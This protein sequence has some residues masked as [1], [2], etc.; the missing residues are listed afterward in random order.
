MSRVKEVAYPP[1]PTCRLCQY[2]LT[3]ICMEDCAVERD[4]RHFKLNRSVE[5]ENYPRFP[6]KEFLEDMSPKVRQ[7]VAAIYL[8]KAFDYLQGVPNGNDSHGAR[9]REALKVIEVESLLARQVGFDS[10]CEDRQECSSE[11]E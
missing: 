8:A 1:Y 4:Y 2:R 10:P 5:F 7:I 11:R 9:S 3:D 6:L